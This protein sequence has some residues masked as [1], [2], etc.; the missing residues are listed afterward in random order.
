MNVFFT[1]LAVSLYLYSAQTMMIRERKQP[2]NAVCSQNEDSVMVYG[3]Q[4]PD[5]YPNKISQCVRRVFQDSR[6][7]IWFGTNSDGAARYDGE[8]LSYLSIRE[9]LSGAQVTGIVEDQAGSIWLSTTG[10]ISRFDQQHRIRNFAETEGLANT[11]VWSIFVDCK[12]M[13]WA[14]TMQGLFRFNGELFESFPLTG[15]EKSWIR[16]IT[17]DRNGNLWVATA[18]QGAFKIS[19]KNVQQLSAADGLCSNDLTCILADKNGNLWF[20]SRDGG[21]SQYDGKNF[22]NFTEGK[23]IGSNEVW[24]IYEDQDGAIWFS[25]EGYGVYY[26]SIGKLCEFGEKQGFPMK[27]VQSVYQDKQHRIWLGGGSGLYLYSGGRFVPVTKNGP[28]EEGC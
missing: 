18:G 10:G 26:Y 16:S 24:T 11:S 22:R 1:G 9:G 23:E 21:L 6:G 2:E 15:A 12:G 7:N 14:G 27:A 17:E 25:S 20:G 4:L 28:W 13:L 3:P 5:Y 19:E 8:G